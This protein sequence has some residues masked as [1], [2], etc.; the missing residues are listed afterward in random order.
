MA[1]HALPMIVKF[2]HTVEYH[3]RCEQVSS[4][5][6]PSLYRLCK[7]LYIILLKNP[8]RVPENSTL[9]PLIHFA[10]NGPVPKLPR[11]PGNGTNCEKDECPKSSV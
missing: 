11:F 2:T 8:K 9:D 3:L 10:V 5:Y 7:I 6:F 1:S 4:Q